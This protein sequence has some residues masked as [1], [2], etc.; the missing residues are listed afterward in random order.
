MFENTKDKYMS[1]KTFDYSFCTLICE[2]CIGVLVLKACLK[3]LHY[4]MKLMAFVLI[5]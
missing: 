1:L 5:S 2:T 4:F 3:N